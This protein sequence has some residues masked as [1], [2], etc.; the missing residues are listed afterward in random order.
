MRRLGYHDTRIATYPAVVYIVM[1]D[2]IP[3]LPNFKKL[4]TQLTFKNSSLCLP[5]EYWGSSG[6]HFRA[7]KNW[8]EIHYTYIMRT[9]NSVHE[10]PLY[11]QIS[12]NNDC[13]SL[14][15]TIPIKSNKTN[16]VFTYGVCLHKSLFN[17]T[18]PE[19][20]LHWVELN[21]AL[22]AEIVTIYLQ[23]GY[24]SESY[25]TLMIPYIKRGVVEVL[26][27]GLRP[28]L[29]PGYTKDWGQTSLINECIYRNMYRVKYL[30]L[31][32]LDEFIVPQKVKTIPEMMYMIEKAHKDQLKAASF[33]VK[34]CYYYKRSS[35]LP[36]VK[37]SQALSH[38]PG[39][40][41]PRYYTFTLKS[42]RELSKYF[43]KMIVRPKFVISA[44]IHWLKKSM[45]GCNISYK[46]PLEDALLH[47][48]R[49]P[50]KFHPL[51]TSSVTSMIMSR[52]F[53][54]TV[55]GIVQYTCR[56]K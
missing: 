21:L 6:S 40:K 26:D 15:D 18:E 44:W 14:T 48:Y 47:H 49:V 31:F 23:N 32:D 1:Y 22:G 43:N 33:I 11:G 46:I 42:Y 17:L 2:D 12:T 9:T 3:D 28:P 37:Q 36:E 41:L 27:W 13:S 35:Q 45:D 30:G 50:E 10:V 20:L 39:I 16:K 54:D 19:T 56:R 55:G 7:R 25:Y 29:I 8:K 4:F 24:I 5:L 34:H 53:N 38:C 51:K 52:Y